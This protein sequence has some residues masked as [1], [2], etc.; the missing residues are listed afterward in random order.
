MGLFSE[1]H[2]FKIQRGACWAHLSLVG[3]GGC[4][5]QPWEMPHVR[6]CADAADDNTSLDVWDISP[7]QTPG[8]EKLVKSQ[9]LPGRDGRV[10]KSIAPRCLGSPRPAAQPLAA[11]VPTLTLHPG[12]VY[13]T[14]CVAPPT[15]VSPP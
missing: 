13:M 1:L 5:L 2:G 15:C 9:L 12:F 7:E 8:K 10:T 4:C 14:T 6:L 11:A 3:A